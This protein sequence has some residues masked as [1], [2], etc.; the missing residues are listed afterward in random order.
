MI[1]QVYKLDRQLC[2]LYFGGTRKNIRSL[3]TKKFSDTENLFT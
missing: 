1:I 3:F 2:G